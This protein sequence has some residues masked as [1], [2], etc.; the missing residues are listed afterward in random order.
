MAQDSE[1]QDRAG[2]VETIGL[3]Q[4]IR[5][6]GMAIHPSKL[7]LALFAL[8]LTFGWGSLLDLLWS[9]QGGVHS[10]VIDEFILSQQLAMPFEERDGTS[11]LFDIWRHYEQRCVEGVLAAAIPPGLSA[12]LAWNSL[13]NMFYGTWWLARHHIVFFLL[14]SIGSLLIWSLFGGAICRMAAME[15]AREE[16]PSI[17]QAL[18]FSRKN[19]FGGF[20]LAPC[21]PLAFIAV[22]MVLLMLGGMVLRVPVFGDLVSGG[23]FFLAIM[24][25]LV[26]TLLS[27]GLLLG[28]SLFWP[29]VA[30]EGSDAFD[31]FSRGLSYT[32]SKPWK[33]V[34][35]AVLT[36]VY[37]AVCWFLAKLFLFGALSVTRA[38]VAIGTSWFGLWNRQ[39]E[40]GPISKLELLWPVAG[41]GI[42]YQAP[43]WSQLAW[44]EYFSAFAI[45]MYVLLMV[46]LLWAFLCSFY[47]SGSTVIYF[48]LRRDVDGTD[49]EEVY[50]EERWDESAPQ[51]ASTQPVTQ[52]ASPASTAASQP[53]AP[54]PGKSES[55]TGASESSPG[56]S[57]SSPSE[58][59]SSPGKS[60]SSPSESESS[61]PSSDTSTKPD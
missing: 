13:S 15:F 10:T 47:F 61:P 7:M 25:G 42:S 8:I 37:A 31:A 5:T 28:G 35:Y 43:E 52:P 33:T 29:T 41:S 60:E 53:A 22:M 27:V 21:V 18:A 3:S 49:L 57:K 45:T 19:F 30:S 48:L 59:K 9:T 20:F 23:A 50:D 51:T 39:T 46:G 16:K 58:S 55:S 44:Y 36:V 12:G 38:V 17:K 24:G 14:L 6:L 11:G 26:I 54:P 1:T 4:I 32:L 56:E 40:A 2:W 34:V